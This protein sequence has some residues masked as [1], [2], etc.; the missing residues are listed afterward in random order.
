M[1]YHEKVSTGILGFDKTIDMLRMGDNVVWQIDQIEDYLEVVKPYIKKARE[2]GRRIVY[3]RFGSHLP[4]LE[5]ADDIQVYHVDAGQGFEQFATNVHQI[6]ENEGREVFYVFDTIAR[7]RETTQCLFDLYMIQGDMYIHPLKADGRYS[8]T[9]F[10]PH[11]IDGERS[12]SITS[13]TKAA[14][15]F[16][17]F[18][19][20]KKRLDFWNVT[21]DHARELLK[22]PKEKQEDMKNLLISLFI[23]KEKRIQSLCRENF[24]L[25]DLLKIV[26]RE[27][28]TGYIGGKSVGMLLA[29]RI[30]KNAEGEMAEIQNYLEPDDSFFLGADVYYTYIVQN[31][32][33]EL[34]LQ[35]KNRRRI[36]FHGR[37]FAGKAAFWKLP[38]NYRRRI[39]SSSGILWTIPGDRSFQFP[40]GG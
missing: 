35:Q 34:R 27:I 24:E 10:F 6:A 18:E 40:A 31:G 1:K 36:F 22:E 37:F 20:D 19:W 39:Y 12:V 14:E 29:R 30:I 16:S 13:S 5:E 23:G 28:G 11:R 38:G 9:M 21:M 26:S 33:W 4:V 3:M 8:P 15:L 17:D 7:I 25:R 2:D 32:W